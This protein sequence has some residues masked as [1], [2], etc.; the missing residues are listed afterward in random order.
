MKRGTIWS[1]DDALE[2]QEPEHYNEPLEADDYTGS[3]GH[4]TVGVWP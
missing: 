3:D 1:W 2:Q 4:G